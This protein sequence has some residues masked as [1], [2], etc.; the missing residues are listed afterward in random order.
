MTRRAIVVGTGKETV[1][2]T[3]PP[4]QQVPASTMT[5]G[6][7]GRKDQSDDASKPAFNLSKLKAKLV[8]LRAAR[9][10]HASVA[11]TTVT[12][13]LGG[14]GAQ[15]QAQKMQI[16]SSDHKK[17][18]DQKHAANRKR[19]KPDTPPQ[20]KFLHSK[21]RQVFQPF[22]K[23]KESTP[24]GTP[25][26]PRRTSTS[27][28]SKSNKGFV[29]FNFILFV[30]FCGYFSTPR[31]LDSGNLVTREARW[32]KGARPPERQA[33]ER[34]EKGAVKDINVICTR[35][36]PACRSVGPACRS[37]WRASGSTP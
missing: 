13:D 16:K 21:F 36:S 8:G 26:K 27:A 31:R 12:D 28:S 18:V 1:R 24:T 6:S 15:A 10:Q 22:S 37:A 7:S 19:T 11:T 34:L 32:G 25:R 35:R 23:N 30:C 14:L 17:E 33:G 3:G 5:M 4:S 9:Q 29:F 20:V 2:S